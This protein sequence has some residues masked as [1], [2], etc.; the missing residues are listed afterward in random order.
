LKQGKSE[1][2]G[3]SEGANQKGQVNTDHPTTDLPADGA[4][5]RGWDFLQEVTERTES[6]QSADQFGHFT[7]G[8][9]GN[10]DPF[11]TNITRFVLLV[12]FC[13]KT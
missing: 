7:E 8:N 12:T 11:P 13:S 1:G 6:Y 10:E 5:K 3:K 4:D 9:K 2:T